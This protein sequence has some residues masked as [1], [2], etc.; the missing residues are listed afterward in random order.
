MIFA[1]TLFDWQIV[2]A[3][4]PPTHQALLVEFPVF[5]AITAKPMLL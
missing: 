4:D 1:L 3:G 5:V 2:D